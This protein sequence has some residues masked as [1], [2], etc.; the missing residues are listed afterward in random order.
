[1]VAMTVYLICTAGVVYG[2]QN[3]MPWFKMEEKDGKLHIIEFF[4]RDQ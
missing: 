1:M 2:I 3:D 4:Y